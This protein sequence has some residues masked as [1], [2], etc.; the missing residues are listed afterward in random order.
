MLPATAERSEAEGAASP[1]RVAQ[2]LGV[3]IA[4]AE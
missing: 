3:H 4:P 1:N 2:I